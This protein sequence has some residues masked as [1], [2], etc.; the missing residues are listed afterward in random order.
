M[1]HLIKQMKRYSV[2]DRPPYL[3]AVDLQRK[4]LKYNTGSK[5]PI[6][7]WTKYGLH[8]FNDMIISIPRIRVH[9]HSEFEKITD[10]VPIETLRAKNLLLKNKLSEQYKL[11]DTVNHPLTIFH[12]VD[13]DD[14]Q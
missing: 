11:T 3:S 4:Q 14:N 12:T 2:N 5:N 1:K 9:P 7:P 6:L 13:K 10:T 8:G